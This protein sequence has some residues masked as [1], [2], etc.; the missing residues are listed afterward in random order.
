[1]TYN[2]N[3]NFQLVLIKVQNLVQGEHMKFIKETLMEKHNILLDGA[4]FLTDWK[5]QHWQLCTRKGIRKYPLLS[6]NYFFNV[7]KFVEHQ[8]NFIHNKKQKYFTRISIDSTWKINWN[9]NSWFLWK[10]S[11][12]HRKKI[13]LDCKFFRF[14]K[15]I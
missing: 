5:L 14:I 10:C 9:C 1:M 4:F 7:K 13:K 12:G 11:I 2:L 8:I 3:K 6:S 15:I